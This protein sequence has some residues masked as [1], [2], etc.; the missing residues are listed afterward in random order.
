MWEHYKKTFRSMQAA[1]A[2]ATIAIY[3]A[4]GVRPIVAAVFFFMMQLG[5]LAGAA[6]AKRLRHKIL[7]S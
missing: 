1:I 2:L 4:F 7:E 5:S 6:W 3:W